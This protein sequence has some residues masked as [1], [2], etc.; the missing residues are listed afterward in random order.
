MPL[1]DNITYSAA[2]S[3]FFHVG[4]KKL[5]RYWQPMWS[6]DLTVTMHLLYIL[7]NNKQFVCWFW[8]QA[9]IYPCMGWSSMIRNTVG[10]PSKCHSE[11]LLNDN[12]KTS[13][14]FSIQFHKASYQCTT[15]YLVQYNVSKYISKH[16][17]RNSKNNTWLTLLFQIFKCFYSQKLLTK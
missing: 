14:C 2:F 12:M 5:K 10:N 6:L 1:Q 17:S 8:K 3:N 13:K 11:K 15:N 4:E 7:L 9:L 16:I